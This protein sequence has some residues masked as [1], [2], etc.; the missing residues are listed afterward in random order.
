MVHIDLNQTSLSHTHVEGG[1]DLYTGKLSNGRDVLVAVSDLPNIS[2]PSPKAT[3]EAPQPTDLMSRCTHFAKD[4]LPSSETVIDYGM[5]TTF[6]LACFLAIALA[7]QYL[8]GSNVFTGSNIASKTP[9]PAIDYKGCI[10]T[11]CEIYNAKFDIIKING[12]IF[13]SCGTESIVNVTVGNRTV[14]NIVLDT[15]NQV[16]GKLFV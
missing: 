9:A 16:C 3:E 8:T 4:Y 2:V 7:D 14:G 10:K 1:G 15:M 13:Y 12:S 6:F 11:V 5:K